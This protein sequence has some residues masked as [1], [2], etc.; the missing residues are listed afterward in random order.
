MRKEPTHNDKSSLENKNWLKESLNIW[1]KHT[2][3]YVS[4]D[5]GQNSY[6]LS[7]SGGRHNYLAAIPVFS[8]KLQY[9]HVLGLMPCIFFVCCS[10]LAAN[11][12]PNY[13]V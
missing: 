11:I 10:I 12:T 13:R 7:C 8:S 2:A 6:Y 9:V 4:I 1:H 5:N 3:P